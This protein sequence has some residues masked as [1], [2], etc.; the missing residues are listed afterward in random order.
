V[1]NKKSTVE[2]HLSF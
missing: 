1:K 2:I